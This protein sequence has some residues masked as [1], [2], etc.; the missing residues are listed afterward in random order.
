MDRQTTVLKLV[1]TICGA[2]RSFEARNFSTAVQ[3]ARRS[4]WDIYRKAKLHLCAACHVKNYRIDRE[5]RR[6]ART[7][8][9]TV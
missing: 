7:V 8:P 1:C 3:E 9:V 4:K 6:I 5:G 2:V